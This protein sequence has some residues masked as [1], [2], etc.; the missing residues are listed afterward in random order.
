[1]PNLWTEKGDALV[2]YM[3][4]LNGSMMLILNISYLVVNFVPVSISFFN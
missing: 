3:V 1:V 4:A 2:M